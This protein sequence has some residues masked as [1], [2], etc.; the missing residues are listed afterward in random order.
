MKT[1]LIIL[2]TLSSFL[3]FGQLLRI[4][5]LEDAGINPKYLTDYELI[6][7]KNK[8][9]KAKSTYIMYGKES[10]PEEYHY[11]TNGKLI[12]IANQP[13]HNNGYR[14]YD[15]KNRLIEKAEVGVN[16]KLKS[17]TIQ[18][19]KFEYDSL[20][21]I[22]R[23]TIWHKLKVV[24]ER[25]SSGVQPKGLKNKLDVYEYVNNY[26]EKKQLISQDITKDSEKG[27]KL[28][29]SYTEFGSISKLEFIMPDKTISASYV[30]IYDTSNRIS[31][32][33]ITKGDA[34][35]DKYITYNTKGQVLNAYNTIAYFDNGLIKT[36]TYAS[37]NEGVNI[38][39]NF[40]YEY[41]K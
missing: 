15:S 34:V 39:E 28:L 5:E 26:N 11:N 37:E 31:Q 30:F 20:S 3:T 33:K 10:T 17:D 12:K 32:I 2:I 23:K 19:T 38:V 21:N 18:I 1:Y 8:V 16:A 4:D 13:G 25:T 6:L 35:A 9:K 22:K 29:Y 24:Y 27:Y 7:K 14:L 40:K 36:I 41:S